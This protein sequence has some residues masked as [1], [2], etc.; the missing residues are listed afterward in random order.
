MF[1]RVRVATVLLAVTLAGCTDA[2]ADRR[3]AE[4][5]AG[6]ATPAKVEAIARDHLAEPT[7][8]EEAEYDGS[9]PR[10]SVGA[11]LD[12]G[13][14]H[15]DV[16]VGPTRP[17]PVEAACEVSECVV[18]DTEVRGGRLTLAW[19]ELVPEED[20]GIIVLVLEREGEFSLV[21]WGGDIEV[22]DDPR[23]L[24][25]EVSVDDAVDL[26]EDQRLRLVVPKH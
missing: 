6:P 20:P 7:A 9:D 22:T 19:Q 2:P 3:G 16:V 25:L 10:G 17:E 8:A 23:E 13:A 15:V 26:L 14:E 1:V 11:R 24:D 4:V 12:H 21:R 18:L 5:K